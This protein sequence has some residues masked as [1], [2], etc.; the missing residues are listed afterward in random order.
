MVAVVPSFARLKRGIGADL[1]G[2]HSA[3]KTT[4]IYIH[5]LNHGS[6]SVRSPVDGL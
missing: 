1:A 6:E 3:V 2:G 4:M 5:V